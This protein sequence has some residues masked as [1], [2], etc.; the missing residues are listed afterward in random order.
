MDFDKGEYMR[1]EIEKLVH[2]TI[3]EE[4]R[5]ILSRAYDLLQEIY[6]S[7]DEETKIGNKAYDASDLI[8][9]I[10]DEVLIKE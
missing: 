8:D 7:F 10:L 1:V 2:V 3:N 6:D 4:E 9:E 5:D